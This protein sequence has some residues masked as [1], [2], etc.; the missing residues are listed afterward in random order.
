MS[1]I[2]PF[3]EDNH[4]QIFVHDHTHPVLLNVCRAYGGEMALREDLPH[5]SFTTL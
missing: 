5:T 2:N 4:G 1:K 3:N